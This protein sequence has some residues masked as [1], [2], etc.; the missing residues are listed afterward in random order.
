MR[1]AT[2]PQMTTMHPRSTP[3]RFG[4]VKR[5]QRLA[6]VSA[7]ACAF[8]AASV[9]TLSPAPAMADFPEP[10][11]APISWE[12]DFTHLTPK[13]I[14]VDI[15]G[16]GQPVA[17]WY[18]VYTVTNNTDEEIFF[19]PVVELLTRQGDVLSANNNIPLSAFEA[20]DRRTRRR[21]LTRPQ[22]M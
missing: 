2:V 8:T 11:Q 19:R 10:S 9:V 4:V 15:P 14:L 7:A 21:N 20:I 6:L 18:M 3:F 12:I 17:Y 13:R 22:D 16:F 1:P 5:L